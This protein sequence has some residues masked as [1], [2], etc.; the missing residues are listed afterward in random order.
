MMSNDDYPDTQP[1]GPPD[2]PD[3]DLGPVDAYAPYEPVMG[4]ASSAGVGV[5]AFRDWVMDNWGGGGPVIDIMRECGLGAP[6]K[7]HE[8]RAWDWMLA[9]LSDPSAPE[10]LIDT[11]LSPEGIEPEAWARRLGLR[12]IIYN[13][14]IWVAGKGWNSYSGA[15]PHTDHVHFGFSWTGAK[16]QTSGYAKSPD[17]ET[18]VRIKGM[19]VV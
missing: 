11:L 13:H 9:A 7:H 6:S 14:K 18:Y 3:P 15:S 4:C 17:G 16:G 2:P 10:Y 1:P 8:G 5:L 19:G 12:T